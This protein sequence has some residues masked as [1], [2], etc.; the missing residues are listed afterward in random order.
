MRKYF[1]SLWQPVNNSPL[2]VFRILFG[3]IM[4]AECIDAIYNGFVKQLYV[5]IQHN[6]TFIG[7]EWL[8][9]LHGK[10]MYVY[11]IVMAVA[12]FFVA[13][14]FAYRFSSALLAVMWSGFY[15]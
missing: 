11:F 2:V 4:M 12:A 6:F 1:S 5:D 14:G 7:F 13:T 9:V 15:L 10:P 3:L 8:Q